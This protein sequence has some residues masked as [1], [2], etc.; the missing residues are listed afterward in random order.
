MRPLLGI[1][2]LASLFL[3]GCMVG[4]DYHRPD[5]PM[6]VTY[7]ELKGWQ[8]AR[9]QDAIDRGAWWSIYRDPVLDGLERQVNVS[10]QTLKESEAAYRNAQALVDE[11][12]AGVFPTL[13]ATADVTRSGRGAGN[14]SSSITTASSGVSSSLGSGTQP[15]TSYSLQG[16]ASWDLDVWGRIRRQ[17]E[18]DVAGAQA[19]AADVANARLSA[20]GALASDYF[21]LRSADSLQTLLNETVAAD[22]R[23]LQITQN[24]YSVG[25]AARSDVVSAQALLE[26][27]QSQAVA[28]AETRGQLEHAIA[29]LTGQPP[30]ALSIPAAPLAD[31]VP[32][33]PPGLPSTLL[34]RRPDVASAERTMQAQNA[35]IGVAVA[36]FYPDISLSALYGFTGAPL[37]TLINASNRVWS[38]GAS[39]SETLFEGGA[40]SATVRA[41]EATYDQSVATYRQAVLTA[42]QQVEDEL[43]ALRVL[44]QQAR[45][46]AA[47]VQDTQRAVA[48]AL[49]QYR[50]GTTAYT[51]VITEQTQLLTDQQTALTIRQNRMVASVALI[52]ALGGGWDAAQLP[53]RD[54]LQKN[55]PLLP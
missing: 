43:V 14:H 44:E 15:T 53:D 35:Q 25:V 13:G 46:Q 27:V 20:Q 26:G 37:G 50:A 28:V 32:V 2:M 34:Q 23:A 17:V 1:T 51:T 45:V 9:P 11:A 16:S 30:A 36:A 5:A 33:V 48:I 55:N 40:R 21:Q 39:A 6:S 4:P 8:P 10:N 22:Q 42:L 47:A 31:Q 38:L 52:Q 12:R 54:S 24:Q 18:S 3:A 7:K 41:A 29:V 19:S 49:N